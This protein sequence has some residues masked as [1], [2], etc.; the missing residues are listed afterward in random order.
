MLVAL[1]RIGVGNFLMYIFALA[2]MFYRFVPTMMEISGIQLPS[3][4]T[5]EQPSARLCTRLLPIEYTLRQPL[6]MSLDP[7]ISG[8]IVCSVK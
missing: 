4:G 5:Q 8:P 3:V 2:F 1:R 6:V 7:S